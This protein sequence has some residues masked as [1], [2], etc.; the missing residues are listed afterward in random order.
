MTEQI[1]AYG[2]QNSYAQGEGRIIMPG[3]EPGEGLRPN[4]GHKQVARQEPHQEPPRRVE[5]PDTTPRESLFKPLNRPE[6]ERPLIPFKDAWLAVEVISQIQDGRDVP[7]S[8]RDIGKIR[9]LNERFGDAEEAKRLEKPEEVICYAQEVLRNSKVEDPVA[10]D[11]DYEQGSPHVEKAYHAEEDLAKNVAHLKIARVQDVEGAMIEPEV[12]AAH[13]S[14]EEDDDIMKPFPEMSGPGASAGRTPAW[15]DHL[16]DPATVSDA[17]LARTIKGIQS[18][19]ASGEDELSRL[20]RMQ[21]KLDD[22]A[23]ETPEAQ[24]AERIL[25]NR[26]RELRDEATRMRDDEIKKSRETPMAEHLLEVTTFMKVKFKEL[27]ATDRASEPDKWN[28]LSGDLRKLVEA[29]EIATE[30]VEEV[31]IDNV[32]PDDMFV[33]LSQKVDGKD[34]KIDMASARFVFE[35][36]KAVDDT[37]RGQ[38]KE[39]RDKII[40]ALSI[41]PGTVPALSGDEVV[42]KFTN[43]NDERT[44]LYRRIHNRYSQIYEND[45]TE[46]QRAK[47]G[48]IVVKGNYYLGAML[49]GWRDLEQASTDI[50]GSVK[51]KEDPIGLRE[52]RA[53]RYYYTLEQALEEHQ[54]FTPPGDPGDVPKNIARIFSWMEDLGL[55]AEELRP[56]IQRAK[57]QL[58]VLPARS[59]E[60]RDMRAALADRIDASALMLA[61]YLSLEEKDM[62]PAAVEGVLAGFE[63][64]K[65]ETVEKYLERFGEDTRGRPFYVRREVD[66]EVF[67]ERVNLYD[68]SLQDIYSKDVNDDR[69]RSNMVEELS[70]LRIDSDQEYSA[71]LMAEIKAREGF[72]DLDDEWKQKVDGSRYKDKWEDEFYGLRDYFRAK[73][74]RLIEDNSGLD[75]KGQPKKWRGANLSID[76]VWARLE[77]V[78]RGLVYEKREFLLATREM[79]DDWKTKRTLH[80][81]F[82]TLKKEDIDEMLSDNSALRVN[83]DLVGFLR[84]LGLEEDKGG[85]NETRKYLEERIGKAYQYVWRE[86]EQ[87]R[88]VQMLKEMNLKVYRG[89]YDPSMEKVTERSWEEPEK[90]RKFK[91]DL[92]DADFDEL[93]EVGYFGSVDYNAF[94]WTWMMQWSAHD[95]VR[96][97]SRDTKS[98]YDDDFDGVVFHHSTNLFHGRARDDL[99]AF[100][101][102]DVENRGRAKQDEVNTIFK[103]AFP[104]KHHYYTPQV[105]MMV[106]WA[107][108]F[109]TPKQ[110]EVVEQRIRQMMSKIDLDSEA[111]HEEAVSWVRSVVIMDMIQNGAL[112]LS[113]KGAKFSQVAKDKEMTKFGFIDYFSDAKKGLEAE[114]PEALQDFLSNPIK[115]KLVRLVS[116]VKGAYSTRFARDH[117]LAVLG[118]RGFWGFV[119]EHD[120]RLFNRRNFNAAAGEG[121]VNDM[122][123]SGQMVRGQ[124]EHEKRKLFGFKHLKL[125]GKWGIPQVAN[126]EIPGIV[127]ATLGT[128]PFRWTRQGLEGL[129][130]IGYELKGTPFG[131][132]IA[133]II[134][135]AKEFIKQGARSMVQQPGR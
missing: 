54:T 111:Y 42:R 106:R 118:L 37:Y 27:L 88:L 95:Y 135:A 18:I 9:E 63:G 78:R 49:T 108:K 51:D 133:A 66:G 101:N 71:S 90:F 39:G 80:G 10:G 85:I 29:A 22:I 77:G 96:V 52:W 75:E 113:S 20:K 61:V 40:E 2:G 58:E 8:G 68:I 4:V 79:I 35:V 46:N 16:P 128:T 107:D 81:A 47:V 84:E 117:I 124:G 60:G 115:G 65:E 122:I 129:R 56:F 134:E 38:D 25:S 127:G 6:G 14:V 19:G 64:K 97:Y 21:E 43:W 104:G 23:A 102:Q 34:E 11:F 92:K 5:N 48:D 36:A 62:H 114:G 112:Y 3:S 30:T 93:E 73:T 69:I 57:A 116:R 82:G 123:G 26:I 103:Q 120:Q 13:L 130:R 91:D 1:L 7:I 55:G 121:L 100:F 50:L 89:T 28:S 12:V 83:G 86:V 87:K 17:A 126:V 32:N 131:A 41:A 119:S 98:K 24:S 67:Y 45:S 110:K 59:K 44:H 105:S 31:E 76:D 132:A 74:S 94:N 72:E 109:M 125:G 33:H 15:Y 99:W 70:R 53:T